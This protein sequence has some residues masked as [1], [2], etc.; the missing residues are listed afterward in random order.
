M[1]EGLQP[2]QYHLRMIPRPSLILSVIRSLSGQVKHPS[3]LDGRW[4]DT[5]WERD[6]ERSFA[7]NLGA[8]A[9][10]GTRGNPFTTHQSRAIPPSQA[11]RRERY[12]EHANP[13]IVAMNDG[14]GTPSMAASIRTKAFAQSL[15]LC[16][17]T[18]FLRRTVASKTGN[19]C[20]QVS[21]P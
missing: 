12:R 14:Q 10:F 5:W 2:E 11:E 21:W 4:V 17:D 1:S 19:K 7:P 20:R 3:C 8:S 9:K 16:Q 13:E 6:W 15:T 18:K